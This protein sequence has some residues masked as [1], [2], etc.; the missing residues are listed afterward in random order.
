LRKLQYFSPL[1]MRKP[2]RAEQCCFSILK[3]WFCC[4]Y[5]QSGLVVCWVKKKTTSDWH[6]S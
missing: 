2:M 5:N 4:W 6:I 1:P 3:I